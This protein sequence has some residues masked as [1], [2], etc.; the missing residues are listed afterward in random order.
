MLRDEPLIG[1]RELLLGVGSTRARRDAGPQH[2]SAPRSRQRG[3]AGV[4]ALAVRS[5]PSTTS[6]LPTATGPAVVVIAVGAGLVGLMATAGLANAG[7]AGR[8][9]ARDLGS[10]LP[11]G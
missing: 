10:L 1:C 11:L 2:R 5:S 3:L 6:M 9:V 4:A 8:A 7:S